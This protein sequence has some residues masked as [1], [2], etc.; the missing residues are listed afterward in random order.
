MDIYAEHIIDLYK[1]PLNKR[2]MPDATATASGANLSCGDR[3][4]MYVKVAN[5]IIADASFQAE[6]CAISQAAASLITDAVIG[7]KLSHAQALSPDDIKE[8]VGVDLGHLR[9]KCA[10]LPLETIQ[11]A[12]VQTR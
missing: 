11:N 8:M 1:H 5:G 12:L 10:L 2:E 7:K 4:R 3:V 9:I 6:G